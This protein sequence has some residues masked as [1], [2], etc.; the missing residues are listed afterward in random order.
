MRCGCIALVYESQARRFIDAPLGSVDIVIATPGRFTDLVNRGAIMMHNV[1]YLVLDEADRMLD[2]GFLPQI[3]QIRR[4]INPK[5]QTVMTSATWP[6]AVRDLGR[7]V[8]VDPF[9][10]LVG[11]LNLSACQEVTQIVYVAQDAQHKETIFDDI[12]SKLYENEK[13]IIFVNSRNA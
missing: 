10:V 5:R 8:T 2:Q 3:N 9:M 6:A 12:V 7:T 13:V 4:Y 11:T 1:S